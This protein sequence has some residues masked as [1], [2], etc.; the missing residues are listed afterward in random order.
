MIKGEKR[1]GAG[2][3]K[4]APTLVI[5]F[6]VPKEKA[7]TLKEQILKLIKNDSQTLPTTTS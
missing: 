4:S 2:R 5:C 7:K 6:R 3:P 1:K